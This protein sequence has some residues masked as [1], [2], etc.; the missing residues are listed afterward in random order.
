MNNKSI[1]TLPNPNVLDKVTDSN[2]FSILLKQMQYLSN[3]LHHYG[4]LIR[5]IVTMFDIIDITAIKDTNNTYRHVSNALILMNVLYDLLSY[6]EQEVQ[7]LRNGKPVGS[8]FLKKIPDSKKR[9]D[10]LIFRYDERLDANLY[11]ENKEQ[12]LGVTKKNKQLRKE[13]HTLYDD[14]EHSFKDCK[15]QFNN[16][17]KIIKKFE[18]HYEIK[19]TEHSIY[20]LYDSKHKI[21]NYACKELNELFTYPLVFLKE[22]IDHYGTNNDHYDKSNFQFVDRV[23]S[24]KIDEGISALSN[25]L[26][27]DNARNDKAKYVTFFSM[28]MTSKPFIDF[29][30]GLVKTFT[31]P[32]LDNVSNVNLTFL[33]TF[34]FV[35][36][37][38]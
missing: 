2:F 8:Y 12:L 27:E 7:S 23:K 20:I 16:Y 37:L 3:T 22:F 28:N 33:F 17:L 29:L 1:K 10:K 30:T 15:E 18:L 31:L 38:E 6:L 9:L 13:F 11:Y 35:T 26:L 5:L 14:I 4:Y 21:F 19:V 36:L 25:I 34:R 24:R 32:A